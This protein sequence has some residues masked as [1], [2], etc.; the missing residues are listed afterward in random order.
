MSIGETLTGSES[1]EAVEFT[2]SQVHI[3]VSGTFGG[4]SVAL[5]KLR[6][7]S[8]VPVYDDGT[9][10][11]FSAPDDTLITLGTNTS[12]RFTS[13]SVTSVYVSALHTNT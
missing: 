8:W 13:T 4:G 6:G 7:G 5:E 9:A 2:S 10:I 1:S 11:T 12:L 3:D